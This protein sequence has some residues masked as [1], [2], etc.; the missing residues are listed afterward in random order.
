[1]T[2][3][4]RPARRAS[5]ALLLAA[6]GGCAAFGPGERRA[7]ETTPD[8]D[9]V[10][11][12]LVF[13]LTQLPDLHPYR[14]T[15]QASPSTTRF[16]DRVLARVADAGYGVQS[17]AADQG[18]RYLRYRAERSESEVGEETRYRVAIGP[19]SVSRAYALVDGRT[20]PSSTLRVDGAEATDI[21]LNDEIFGRDVP[22]AL[23]VASFVNAGEPAILDVS[24]GEPRP[25]DVPDT[26]VVDATTAEPDFSTLVRRNVY[27]MMRSNYAE[28]FAD[29]EDV[30]Q[31]V[32][33]FPN[34]SL[35]LGNAQ[36]A[37]IAEYVRELDPATDILSVIGCSHGRSAL[38]NGNE[39]LA[40]GR[41]NR[42]KEAFL[43]AGVDHEQVL[44]EGCWAPQHFDEV[45]PRRGVVLTLKRRRESL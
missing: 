4:T 3:L 6:L 11:Q 25:V 5:A 24:G 21:A 34:D 29:Y 15:V 1:M 33:V 42:V 27:E 40:I 12:N 26:L 13:A 17:V 28:L 10:A 8:P 44:E 38:D 30:R 41:A 39:V 23:S 45:M 22:E 7:T 35:R 9:L 43:F 37:T 2:T 14:T 16:G 31:D 19:F 18:H 32:L 36:K 20:V